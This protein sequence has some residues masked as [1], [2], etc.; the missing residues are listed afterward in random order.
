MKKFLV[1]ALSALLLVSAIS[2]ASTSSSSAPVSSAPAASS[3]A[4]SSTGGSS[5]ASGAAGQMNRPVQN[6]L[7]VIDVIGTIEKE[8]AANDYPQYDWTIGIHSY[9]PG[10]ENSANIANAIREE[11]GKY[12]IKV[13]E[14]Y[15]NMDVSKYPANY[16]SFILQNV[17]LILDAGW[18]GNESVID[19]ADAAGIPVVAYDTPFDSTRSWTIGGDPSV[20]GSTIGAYMADEVK[21]K[22]DGEVD[23][24]VISWSQALGEPMR[25]RMQSAIDAMRENGLD[26]PEDK[27]FWYDGGGETLKSKTIM[28]DF[29]TANPD[30]KRILVGANTGN[31]A[32]GMLAAV[33]TAGRTE[34][35]MIYSYGA[36]QVAL[37]NFRGK[38]NCWV[39][40][41]GYYFRQ[42]GWLGVNTAIRILNGEEVGDWVSPENYV[43]NYDNVNDYQG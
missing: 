22:W 16:E 29:L 17:D 42:Y 15:C 21:N 37:D 8:Q 40:D 12:G 39:A 27:I 36:E 31:V 6:S 35:V 38:P 2:C 20:A 41:V 23:A 4:A 14:S 43:I 33:E 9:D 7:E 13:I 18:L 5:S 11:A 19:I 32:Q 26:I 34:D 10:Y 1:V 3:S 25:I 30:A 24:I 28:A